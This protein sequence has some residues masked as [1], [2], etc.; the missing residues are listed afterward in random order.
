MVRRNELTGSQPLSFLDFSV[1]NMRN[2]KT[3]I[4]SKVYEELTPE[5][6][7]RLEERYHDCCKVVKSAH[8]WI[9]N[10]EEQME[11]QKQLTEQS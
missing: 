9:Q 3:Q 5:E 4:Q 8:N 1:Y 7:K 6:K 10:F 2:M 11:K